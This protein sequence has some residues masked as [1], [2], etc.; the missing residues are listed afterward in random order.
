M[1]AVVGVVPDRCYGQE[2]I[3]EAFAAA[4]GADAAATRSVLDRIHANAGVTTRHLVLPLARYAHLGSFREAND[5]F[6]RHGVDLGARALG[7]ALDR[8]G[9][10]ADDVDLLVT[11]TVTGLA[12]PSLDARIAARL[13][14]RDDVRRLPIVGLGCVAGAAGVARIRDHLAGHPAH[15]AT[16][17]CVEL[18]SL[19]LQRD[20]LSAANLVASGLFG[21]G[22]AAVLMTG[23]DVG[24]A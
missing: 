17:V 7:E 14:L 21:D 13:R 11:C 9:L 12:V 22:A 24:C 20:D 3:T 5:E 15:V 10:R 6:I 4:V 16:L 23:A 2:A 8:A 18:C 1:R 19:T